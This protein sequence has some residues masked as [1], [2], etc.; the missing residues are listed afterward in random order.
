[1]L[2][3]LANFTAVAAISLMSLSA[4]AEVESK[5]TNILVVWGDDIGMWNGSAY[6]RSMMGYQTSNIDRIANEGMIFTDY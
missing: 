4:T 6:S 2:K 5:K 1:M 3:W